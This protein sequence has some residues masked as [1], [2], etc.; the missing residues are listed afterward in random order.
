MNWFKKNPTVEFY[1]LMPEIVDLAPIQNARNFR[2]E[3]MVNATK[4]YAEKK[5]HPLFGMVKLITTAKCPG[6]YNYARYGWVMTTWQDLV[7]ET[8]GDGSSFTWYT[9]IDQR[10][11]HSVD[12]IGEMVSSHSKEQYADYIGGSI[13]NSIDTVIK[14]NTPW[15]CNVPEG[16]FLQEAPLP[17]TTEKRFTTITG[18]YSKEVGIAQMNV[19]LLWHVLKGT[20][21]IKAGTPIA[22]YMLIPK[23]QPNMRC[24]AATPEQVRLNK[25][26]N[27]ETS[28]HYVSDLK[29]RKC[30]FSKLLK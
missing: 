11:V 13:P 5:K 16:Y 7:I 26:T 15:R 4:D 2:P 1:S 8:N 12:T 22:H 29:E 10:S 3:L 19:Q 17:Y 9:P 21:L 28:R 6:I 20:T 24:V 27:T 18:F 25:L 30:I 14:I 23:E